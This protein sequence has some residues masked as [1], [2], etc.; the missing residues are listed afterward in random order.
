MLGSDDF[1]LQENCDPND[2]EEAFLW[3]LVGPPGMKGAPLPFPVVYLR[4]VSKRLWDTGARPGVGEQL[5]EY[6]RP[7]TGDTNALFASG[8]WK[9]MGQKKAPVVDLD[10][11]EFSS[12]IRREMARQLLDNGDIPLPPP[13]SGLSA[14]VPEGEV[15]VFAER[16]RVAALAKLC[17][18]ANSEVIELLVDI[19][20]LARKPQSTIDRSTAQQVYVLLKDVTGH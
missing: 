3:Q 15:P 13:E 9:K 17:G 7:P 18:V 16:I 11:R 4:Q 1:P 6:H 14:P 10:V 12:D 8:E 19:G 2:P 20:S 5:I